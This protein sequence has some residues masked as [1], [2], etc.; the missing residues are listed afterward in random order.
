M[1]STD[2]EVVISISISGKGRLGADGLAFWYT[3]ERS[4]AGTVYGSMDHW[5]GLGVFLDTFDNDNKR[6]NPSIRAMINDGSKSFNVDQ[7][8]I[9]WSLGEGC[10]EVKYRNIDK[11]KLK[12]S[13][14]DS[15]L[16]VMYDISGNYQ[17]DWIICVRSPVRLPSGYYFG[18]SAA[19]GGLS[20]QHLVEMFKTWT[21]GEIEN[22]E[23]LPKL[24]VAQKASKIEDLR[25]KISEI[26]PKIELDVEKNEKDEIEEPLITIQLKREL[27]KVEASLHKQTDLLIQIVGNSEDLDNYFANSVTKA[28]FNDACSYD[29][30]DIANKIQ[31]IKDSIDL[32]PKSDD[33]LKIS[34][35]INRQILPV[36]TL[37]ERL[38]SSLES[39]K[40]DFTQINPASGYSTVFWISIFYLFQIIVGFLIWFKKTR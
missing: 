11:F 30:Q 15:V 40:N 22:R 36:K 35:Y 20:D 37:V 9:E 8:G 28:D 3:E 17:E 34:N 33:N 5:N 38:Q 6:D 2:W 29:L 4:K 18:I 32:I 27:L 26:K 1:D 12:I 25:S 39:I 24:E 13:L 10:K 21:Y 16:L 14:I 7:D 23:I 31:K 19:T